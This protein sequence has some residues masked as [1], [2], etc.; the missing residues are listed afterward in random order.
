M[1]EN[2][3]S[4]LTSVQ[5]CDRRARESE[6]GRLG[7]ASERAPRAA[8]NDNEEALDIALGRL[9]S[10]ATLEAWSRVG[11]LITAL[12]LVIAAGSQQES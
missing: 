5:D 10:W 11:K 2:D 12:G 6:R 9:F 4:Y 1:R 3:A 8:T 7:R